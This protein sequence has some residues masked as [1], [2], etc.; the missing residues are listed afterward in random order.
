MR[1]CHDAS[2]SWEWAPFLRRL[3]AFATTHPDLDTNPL[4]SALT[5]A[6]RE[7]S[8]AMND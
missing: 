5:G 8:E 6:T 3:N 4:V 7:A 2:A 1:R